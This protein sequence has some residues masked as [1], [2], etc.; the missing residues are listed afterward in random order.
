M[1]LAAAG[2]LVRHRARSAIVQVVM[3]SDFAWSAALA[4]RLPRTSVA[5]A[6][7]GDATD[8]I[9]GTR[10]RL[11]RL[12]A[13]LRLAVLRRCRHVALSEMIADELASIG[14]GSRTTVIPVPVDR[15]HFRPP[16]RD[17]RATAR[18]QLRLEAGEFVVV[19]TGHLRA[20]KRIDLLVEAFARLVARHPEAHLLL[21]GGS[22]EVADACETQ[23]RRQVAVLG[24]EPRVTFTGAVSD[25]RLHLW[26][27]DVFVLPSSREGLSNSL[28]EAMACGLACV[29]PLSAGGGEVLSDGAGLVPASNRPSDLLGALV[30]LAGDPA[31]R[32]RLASAAIEGASR[33]DQELVTDAYEE[34]YVSMTRY[35]A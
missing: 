13:I 33:Y 8:E 9:G 2:W 15:G 10:G 5:W 1:V 19:Y 12:Q 14:L 25:V 17:E 32:G 7:L 21:V 6:G 11:R 4:G 29:A 23:L 27:A 3:Y 35:D 20:L 18:R 24:A 22:G 31:L 16:T 34:L 28:L 30:A 26:A